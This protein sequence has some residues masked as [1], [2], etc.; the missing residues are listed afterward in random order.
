MK[1]QVFSIMLLIGLLAACTP[2]APPTTSPLDS[3]IAQSTI[4]PAVTGDMARSALARETARTIPQQDT[5]ALVAGNTAF[6]VDM[7]HA[8]RDQPGNLFYSPHSISTALAMTYAGARG[9]TAEEMAQT[10]HFT[11]PRERFYP[12][13]NALDLALTTSQPATEDMQP[14]TL[15]VVNSLWGERT[16]TFLPEYLDLLALHYGA[17]MR[18]TDYIGNPEGARQAINAWVSEQTR[19][20]IKD[21]IPAGAIDSDTRLTLVNAIYFKADWVFQFEERLTEDG[22]FNLL[23]GSQ[24]TAAMM[25]WDIPNSVAYTS[26]PGYQAVELPYQGGTASMVLL[27]PDAGK[28][29]GFESELT[30]AQLD[31]TLKNLERRSVQLSL[32]QFTFESEFDLVR[33]LAG[34]GMPTAMSGGQADFSGMDGTR[35]L[36][37]GA[38]IH[39]A[40]VAV[41]E[42]GTE[43]AAATAVTMRL[44]SLPMEDVVLTV[45]R[46]FLFLIR[47]TDTGAIL[48]IGRV[49]N[50]AQ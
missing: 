30:A 26:A 25:H 49:M 10:L 46:P 19:E 42:K 18:L 7:Y 27:V 43:A 24:V 17:G 28:F 12:A 48:F 32:P 8:L 44:T 2:T 23:D 14:F 38:V 6:A 29:A 39:K 16:Y 36:S 47:D 40:F 41:D 37:I 1:K 50:P 4:P 5:A 33:T 31:A 9:Q 20:R 35:N 22:D 3:P 15:D 34:L 13:F 21:L 45:D 11:L